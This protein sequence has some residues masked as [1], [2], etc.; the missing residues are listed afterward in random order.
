MGRRVLTS[1][2]EVKDLDK[3]P[4]L[5][6]IPAESIVMDKHTYGAVPNSPFFSVRDLDIVSGGHQFF[7]SKVGLSRLIFE[8]HEIKSSFPHY[9]EVVQD[10]DSRD[11]SLILYIDFN[12]RQHKVI[13]TYDEDHPNFAMKAFVEYPSLSHNVMQGHWY[14]EK[15]PCYIHSWNRSWTALKVA[16]QMCFWF[17]DYYN[18]L[19]G[20]SAG[21]TILSDDDFPVFTSGAML[22]DVR[23]R[24]D[25]YF[26]RRHRF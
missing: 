13:I 11:V 2:G 3:T 12:D 21:R 16:T 1:K 8:I 24:L 19:S 17:Y 20:A 25:D 22:D 23:R 26:D 14:G 7:D 10:D 18:E 5:S 9:C 15:E 4:D 6:E